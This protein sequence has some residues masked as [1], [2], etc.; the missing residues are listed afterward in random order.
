M[1]TCGWSV[2]K[3]Y[4]DRRIFSGSAAAAHLVLSKAAD[5]RA[6]VV[7]SLIWGSVVLTGLAKILTGL[8]RGRQRWWL[9]RLLLV[10]LT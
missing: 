6:I 5:Q 2:A 1:G 8:Q 9:R 10:R 4:F 3:G 7:A